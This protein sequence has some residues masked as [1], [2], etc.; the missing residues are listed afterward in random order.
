MDMTQKENLDRKCSKEISYFP[1]YVKARQFIKE[2]N[3]LVHIEGSEYYLLRD[4]L[5]GQLGGDIHA[6]V[7]DETVREYV[8]GFLNFNSFSYIDLAKT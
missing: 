7:D 3:I 4:Y 8:I 6:E 2:G 5:Y 1:T